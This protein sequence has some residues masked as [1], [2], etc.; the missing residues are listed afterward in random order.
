M[1]IEVACQERDELADRL[2]EIKSGTICTK[3][4]QKYLDGVHQCCMELL[5]LNIATKQRGSHQVSSK[6]YCFF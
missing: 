3:N 1:E 5:S 6:K 4:G 2:E